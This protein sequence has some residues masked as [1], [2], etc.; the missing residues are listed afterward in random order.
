MKISFSTIGCPDWEWNTVLSRAKELG[1]NGIEVRGLGGELYAPRAV[2]FA[3]ERLEETKE[4]L[5]KAGLCVSIFTSGASLG[6]ENAD[7]ALDEARDYVDLAARF[8]VPFVRVM[9]CSSPE[10]RGGE[11]LAQCA[12]LYTELCGYAAQKGVTPLLE[13]NG[14]L[15]SSLEMAR[16]MDGIAQDNKGVLWDVHHP[17]RFFGETP[18]RTMANIGPLVRHVHLKD[19]LAAGTDVRYKLLGEGDVPVF[20][21]LRLLVE[22]GYEGFVSLEWVKR[23]RPELQEPE[24][25]FAQFMNYMR[26]KLK[27][28]L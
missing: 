8:G 10:P 27:K 22:A 12:A 11:D 14:P 25:V 15:G 5:A 13:T 7:I 20:P 6:V 3:A 24:V 26:I 23:W 4:R 18:E 17:F 28:L 19:S 2:P 1:V 9:V 16:F 21:A